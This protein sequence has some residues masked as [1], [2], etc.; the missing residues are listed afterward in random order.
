[1]TGDAQLNDAPPVV[2]PEDRLRADHVQIVN[3]TAVSIGVAVFCVLVVGAFFVRM[4]AK[5]QTR[6]KLAEFEFT[7][8]EPDTEEFELREPQ[9][10]ILKE[11]LDELEEVVEIEEKPDIH[12]TTVPTDV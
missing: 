9:R 5:M 10:D 8:D 7:V 11:Q 4:A 3:K 2:S 12:I 1:M 6:K